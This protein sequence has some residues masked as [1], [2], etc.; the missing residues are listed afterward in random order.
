MRDA[1]RPWERD[2]TPVPEG[3]WPSVTSDGTKYLSPSARDLY[4]RCSQAWKYRYM[5]RL[6]SKPAP[7]A[8]V[9]TFLHAVMEQALKAQMDGDDWSA[10]AVGDAV[11]EAAPEVVDAA[12]PALQEDFRTSIPALAAAAAKAWALWHGRHFEPLEVERRRTV[13]VG[14]LEVHGLGVMDVLANTPDG[15]A[16]I[17]WKFP[18]KGAWERARKYATPLGEMVGDMRGAHMLACSLYADAAQAERDETVRW[19]ATISSPRTP[20]DAAYLT[21]MRWDRDRTR[22]VHEAWGLAIDG[23]RAARFVPRARAEWMCNERF[24]DYWSVCPGG[25]AKVA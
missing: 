7:D 5:D 23:I 10:P 11:K 20:Q 1:V 21:G 13:F 3:Q 15:L 9:G 19:I 6:P 4:E 22:E 12:D 14:D 18:R 24:C 25:G 16:V 17:D 2:D 8:T